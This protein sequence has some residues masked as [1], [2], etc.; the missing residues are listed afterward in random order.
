MLPICSL[1]FRRLDEI[2]ESDCE[3]GAFLDLTSIL[4][5]SLLPGRF[6]DEGECEMQTVRIGIRDSRFEAIDSTCRTTYILKLS[7]FHS[8]MVL[9]HK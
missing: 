8:A 6:E 3:V 4:L 2:Q 5:L 9:V 7:P 1:E